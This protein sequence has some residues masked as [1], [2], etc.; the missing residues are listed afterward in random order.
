MVAKSDPSRM[1]FPSRLS[2]AL[3]A[4]VAIA[5]F[6]ATWLDWMAE[7]GPGAYLAGAAAFA[8]AAVVYAA[9]RPSADYYRLRPFEASGEFYARLGVRFFRRFVPLGDYFNRL[10]RRSVPDFRAVRSAGDVAKWE[11]FGRFAER[12]H[13]TFLVFLVPPTCWGLVCG[14]YRFAAEQVFFNVLVNLY[15]I[16]VQRYTRARLDALA[17]RSDRLRN[18][19]GGDH[20]ETIMQ[21]TVPPK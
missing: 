8:L 6:L 9:L 14:Q 20:R 3:G 11:R 5:I 15:P 1:R 10:T 21:G 7:R 4:G 16:M 12:I 13:A 17:R 18:H 19:C 2:I